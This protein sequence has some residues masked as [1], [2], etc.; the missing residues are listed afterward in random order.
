MFLVIELELLLAESKVVLFVFLEP[1]RAEKGA[2]SLC[3]PVADHDVVFPPFPVAVEL[4]AVPPI[5]LQMALPLVGQLIL[6]LF[7][8]KMDDAPN[9]RADRGFSR[10]PADFQQ[11]IELKQVRRHALRVRESPSEGKRVFTSNQ[12][13]K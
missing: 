9:Q 4:V 1:L 5:P 11:R 12:D 8:R 2:Q 6:R 10:N 3:D 13:I 7:L